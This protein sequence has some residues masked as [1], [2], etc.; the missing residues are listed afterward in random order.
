MENREKFEI[1]TIAF[2]AV[3]MLITPSSTCT[4]PCSDYRPSP[5]DQGIL[6]VQNDENG[7]GIDA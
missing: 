6:V 5:T 1:P 7:P 3:T 4:S 2:T